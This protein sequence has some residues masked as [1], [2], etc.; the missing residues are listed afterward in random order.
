MII[1][2]CFNDPANDGFFDQLVTF[3]ILLDLLYSHE[4]YDDMYE[5]FEKIKEKQ[6]N[7][8][9][10]PKYPVVLILAACYKQVSDEKNA[11]NN[12]CWLFWKLVESLVTLRALP[13]RSITTLDANANSALLLI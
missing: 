10:Y 2:Q 3:Q 7:M 4:M 12:I 1:F 5:L 11:T 9:K 13:C 8:T 6:I